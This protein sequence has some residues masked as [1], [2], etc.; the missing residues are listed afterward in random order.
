MIHRL[1][2][3]QPRSTDNRTVFVA[4]GHFET[5]SVIYGGY[6]T[7]DGFLD[8]SRFIVRSFPRLFTPQDLTPAHSVPKQSL[9]ASRSPPH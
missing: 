1:F 9:H 3:L 5:L 7:F 4:A 8:G 2:A 6:V